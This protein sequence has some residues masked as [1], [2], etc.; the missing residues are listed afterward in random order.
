M[1]TFEGFSRPANSNK[2]RCFYQFD[3]FRIDPARRLL[4][5]DGQPVPL[6][7]KAFDVLLTL[8]QNVV[9][10]GEPVVS[11]D[12]LM[13]TVWP[14]TFVEESNLAQHV[15]VLRKTLGEAKGENRYI[16]TEPGRGYRFAA[17]VAVVSQEEIVVEEKPVRVDST[18]NGIEIPKPR[19]LPVEPAP[20]LQPTPGPKTVPTGEEKSRRSWKRWSALA[21]ALGVVFAIALAISYPKLRAYYHQFRRQSVSVP[22]EK[23]IAVLPLATAASDDQ[24][25]ILADGLVETITSKLAGIQNIQGKLTVVPASEV[26]AHIA[27]TEVARSIFGA[28]L[29]LTGSAQRWNDRI[30][31]TL[32]LVDTATARQLKSRKFEL[33]V[34]NPIKLRDKVT[35]GALEMLD[36]KLTPAADSFITDGETSVPAAYT[37]YLKGQGYLWRG[38]I[39]G[40]NDRAIDSLAEATRLDPQYALAFVA[41]GRAQW[42]KAIKENSLNENQAAVNTILES[43]RLAPRL[44]EGHV[45]LGEIYLQAGR[46]A[47]AVQEGRFALQLAPDNARAYLIL[48]NAYFRGGQYDQAGDAYKK[49]VQRQPDY[50][51]AHIMLGWFYVNRERYA[52]ARSEYQMALQLTPNN[53]MACRSLAGLDM[54][55]GKFR[56]ASDLIAKTLDFERTAWKYTT[57]GAAYYYQ[58]RYQEAASAFRSGIALDPNLYTLWGN[59]ADAYRHIPGNESR[60][61]ESLNKAIDLAE[62]HLATAPADSEAH[63]ELAQYFA[64]LGQRDRALA[65]IAKIPEPFLLTFADRL[66]PAYVLIGERRLAVEMI[67]KLPPNSPALILIG[68]YPDLDSL[69][70]DAALQGLR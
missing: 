14:G 40:S 1:N 51:Y 36:L 29:V 5:R 32:D 47:E 57:L 63:A 6:Q 59:L 4:T 21:L 65:E 67:R 27:T 70:Q 54:R 45:T 58:R 13:K 35:R 31:F 69:W 42:L 33:E 39:S 24:T 25:R 37:A 28:N 26:R 7:P 68:N 17:P 15:S 23:R 11:K 62:K 22:D 9:M 64:A 19:L 66:V 46:M 52:D 20:I 49:A 2:E 38:D 43:I 61:R 16:V 41:L 44:A 12:D 10:K 3:P 18:G 8:V 56:D 60:A 34:A 30:Q 48:G 55:E 50:W 53:E